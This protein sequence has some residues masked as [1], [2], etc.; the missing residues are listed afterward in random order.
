[1]GL[2]LAALIGVF[3]CPSRGGMSSYIAAGNP[4]TLPE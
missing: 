2:D 4:G 3:S 1:M